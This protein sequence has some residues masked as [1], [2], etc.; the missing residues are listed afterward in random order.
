MLGDI[1]RTPVPD[2]GEPLAWGAADNE[3]DLPMFGAK[4]RGQCA[5]SIRGSSEVK[6]VP[7]VVAHSSEARPFSIP[8]E[9]L[10][11]IHVKF[12]HEYGLEPGLFQAE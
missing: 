5:Q 3:S 6:Y 12:I 4:A 11:G 1:E 9:R 10:H 2:T 8:Q 7:H